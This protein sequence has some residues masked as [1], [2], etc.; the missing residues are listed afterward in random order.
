MAACLAIM[1]AVP[2]PTP[3]GLPSGTAGLAGIDVLPL[4]QVC[5]TPD[6]GNGAFA[7]QLIPAGTFIGD[8]EGEMLDEAA[9]WH[10]Y[11]SG[12]VSHCCPQVCSHLQMLYVFLTWFPAAVSCHAKVCQVLNSSRR[13]SEDLQEHGQV[14]KH[15]SRCSL[16]LLQADHCITVDQQWTLDGAARAK[17]TRA[18][19]PCHMNHS[20]TRY[21]VARHT[22]RRQ[23][24]VAFY[25]LRDVQVTIACT[26]C[27]VDA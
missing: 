14:L 7:A 10:R 6:R 24:R 16:A 22:L 12:M 21:N 13:A 25:T 19:S 5:S 23:R 15:L 2:R 11:P 4:A 17:D 20:A 9:Y 8:Y 27:H 26:C 1:H 18:F 3:A